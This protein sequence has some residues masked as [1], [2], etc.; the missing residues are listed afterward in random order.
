[1]CVC[2]CANM[3]V[4]VCAS[5][6]VFMCVGGCQIFMIRPRVSLDGTVPHVLLEPVGVPPPPL[7]HHTQRKC[8]NS[9]PSFL[10]LHRPRPIWFFSL[11]FLSQV[12]VASISK[13]L[14]K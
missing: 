2:I 14:V 10:H 13:R 5:V 8:S 1:M 11:Y 12:N 3:Y 4:C 9:S 6:C 7:P